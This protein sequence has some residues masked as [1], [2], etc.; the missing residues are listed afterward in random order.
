MM[1]RTV[2]MWLMW[3]V[4]GLSMGTMQCGKPEPS[5][6]KQEPV[7]TRKPEPTL[8]RNQPIDAVN[9]DIAKQIEAFKSRF[10]DLNARTK[11]LDEKQAKMA[12]GTRVELEAVFLKLQDKQ[13]SAASLLTDLKAAPEER[14][15]DIMQNVRL[16]L[17]EFQE[18]VESCESLA[19]KD[20]S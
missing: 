2:S 6:R 7:A 11:I 19:A 4:I 14:R 17:S 8:S 15:N 1:N 10:D 16:A 5:V 13:N 20:K 9:A 3:V 18:M 12:A